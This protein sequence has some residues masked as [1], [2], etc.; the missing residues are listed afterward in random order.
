MS[1]VYTHTQYPGGMKAT[2]DPEAF[3]TVLDLFDQ[4]TKEFADKPAYTCMGHTLTYADI[5]R[6]SGNFAAY[7]Q[8]ETDLQPGD[9]IAVQ[10]AQHSAIPD[11]CVRRSAGRSGRG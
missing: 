6:L 9:R 5:D 1:D 11:C 4:K 3:D 8:N 7:L 10:F 2:I